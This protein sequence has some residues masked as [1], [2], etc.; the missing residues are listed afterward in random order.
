MKYERPEEIMARLTGTKLTAATKS[1]MT[2]GHNKAGHKL[3]HIKVAGRI[4]CTEED[5]LEFLGRDRGASD[6]ATTQ[7]KTRSESARKKASDEA[8]KALDSMGI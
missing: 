3:K 8:N 2:H 5:L 4:M 1:R 6:N 7:P